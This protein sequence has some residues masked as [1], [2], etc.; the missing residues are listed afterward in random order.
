MAQTK[1]NRRSLIITKIRTKMRRCRMRM[2]GHTN[3]MNSQKS[4]FKSTGF[5]RYGTSQAISGIMRSQQH[6]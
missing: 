2:M 1:R 4:A 3:M 6:L 5:R